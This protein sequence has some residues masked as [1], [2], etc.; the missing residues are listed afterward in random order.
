MEHYGQAVE[1]HHDIVVCLV[2]VVGLVEG[3]NKTT[4]GCSA[5]S[6]IVERWS[7]GELTELALACDL[8][9]EDMGSAVGDEA[10]KR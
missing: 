7:A 1:S 10:S 3:V 2:N 5:D 8:T 6:A 9:G 4:A